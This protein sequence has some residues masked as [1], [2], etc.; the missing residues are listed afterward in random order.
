MFQCN[1]HWIALAGFGWLNHICIELYWSSESESVL[2]I[3]DNLQ[4]ISSIFFLYF[5][6]SDGIFCSGSECWT[7]KQVAKRGCGVCILEDIQYLTG[8]V[9][10]QLAV[11]DFSSGI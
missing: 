7:P 1:K 8:H 3:E 10:E 6:D 4:L 2:P 11:A 5:G 9:P